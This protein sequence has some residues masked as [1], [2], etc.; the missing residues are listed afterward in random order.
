MYENIQELC[1]ILNKNSM[2]KME[3]FGK[4]IHC[5]IIGVENWS[6]NSVVWGETCNL[7]YEGD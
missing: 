2:V 4:P 6:R 5:V 3:T 1:W 7:S